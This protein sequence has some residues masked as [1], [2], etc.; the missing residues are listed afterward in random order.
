MNQDYCCWEGL[1]VIKSVPDHQ[2]DYLQ[3]ALHILASDSQEQ[4]WPWAHH[5]PPQASGHSSCWSLRQ[6]NYKN[7][8][9]E[10]L[11]I[12]NNFKNLRRHPQTEANHR[13]SQ[14]K[15]NCAMIPDTWIHKLGLEGILLYLENLNAASFQRYLRSAAAPASGNMAFT[16]WEKG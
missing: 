14:T 6:K 13:I 11:D 1:G 16:L 10:N 9:E 4:P 5:Q 7:G 3:F 12:K 2:K 8:R 15:W